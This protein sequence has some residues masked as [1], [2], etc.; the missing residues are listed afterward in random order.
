MAAGREVYPVLTPLAI[1]PTHP[2]PLI[3]NKSLNLLV[4][5][6]NRRRKK[7]KPLMAIVPVP[8]ILPRL[9][10]IEKA[11]Q[12]GDFYFLS[13]VVRHFVEDLFPGHDAEGAWAF[14]ITRNS[15]LYAD[16]EEIEK[17]A[18]LQLR[19]NCTIVEK[20]LQ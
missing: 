20:G 13:E 10:K 1:D 3:L 11:R 7:N 14:R 4:A 12:V 15:H 2:F 5:L 6:R 9:V 19:R 8:R 18:P 17:L 16:E